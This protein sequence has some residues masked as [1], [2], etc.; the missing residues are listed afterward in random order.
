MRNS[1][2]IV[3]SLVLLGFSGCGSGGEAGPNAP[4]SVF[5]S[6]PSEVNTSRTLIGRP[7]VVSREGGLERLRADDLNFRMHE[8]DQHLRFNWSGLVLGIVLGV[9]AIGGVDLIPDWHY[10]FLDISIPD[11]HEILGGPESP[12]G[13]WEGQ[14]TALIAECGPEA[15]GDIR[16]FHLSINESEGNLVVLDQ[17]GFVY[18]TSGNTDFPFTAWWSDQQGS[19]SSIEF[20]TPLSG[21]AYVKVRDEFNRDGMLCVQEYSGWLSMPDSDP[22]E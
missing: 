3:L 16:S 5:S 11:T 4:E 12:N 8:L 7:A 19:I 17:D 9:T 15:F 6:T 22:V 21:E 18:T 13:L 20:S 10:G 14:L 1:A 2:I